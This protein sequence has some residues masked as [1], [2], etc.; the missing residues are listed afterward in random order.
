MRPEYVT[1]TP[2]NGMAVLLPPSVLRDQY[3]ALPL[4]GVLVTYIYILV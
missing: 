4:E 3:T 2:T 1:R